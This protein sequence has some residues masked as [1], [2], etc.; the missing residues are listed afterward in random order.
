M[1]DGAG[2]ML[3]RCVNSYACMTVTYL[4]GRSK[5]ECRSQREEESREIHSEV[6]S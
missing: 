4:L 3:E 5:R 1:N 2:V 6:I